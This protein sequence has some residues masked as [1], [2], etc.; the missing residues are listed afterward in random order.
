MERS[1]ELLLSARNISKSFGGIQALVN[2]RIDLYRGKICGMLGANGAGKSTFSNIIAGHISPSGGS[3]QYQG[4]PFTISSARDALNNGIALVAQETSLVPDL[5]VLENIFLPNLNQKG[6]LSFRL[7]RMRAN[8]ILS[9]LGGTHDL[10]LEREVKYLSAAQRQLI[11]IAKALALDANIIIFDE[12]TSSLSPREVENLFHVM[13]QIK[14]NDSALIFVS[15]RLEEVFSITDNVTILREGQCVAENLLTKELTQS[16]VIRYMVGKEI[17]NIYQMKRR[18][19]QSEHTI[20][21]ID[22]LKSQPWVQNVSFSLKKGEILGL[23]GLVGAGRSEAMEALMGI[24]P[25][26]AGKIQLNGKIANIKS[27]RS[28]IAAGL[29]FIAED[30]KTHNVFSDFNV[31]DNLMIA[32]MGQYKGIGRGYKKKVDKANKLLKEL[33]ISTARL[34]SNLTEF[35]GGMQQKIIIA[36]WLMIEPEILILDEPTKGVDIG[37]RVAIYKILCN[38]ADAGISCIVISSDFE[39][40]LGICERIVVLSDGLTIA[41]LPSFLLNEEKL[42]LLAAPRSSAKLNIKILKYLSNKYNCEAFW[43]LI[44]KDQI[45]CLALESSQGKPTTTGLEVGKATYAHQTAIPDALKHKKTDFFLERTNH[46]AT[47]LHQ[48]GNSRG[49]DFGW[50]GI[51]MQNSQ[52]KPS[53]NEIDSCISKMTSA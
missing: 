16:D 40:L 2:A 17:K 20:L 5:T 29:G 10:P 28:A 11:E 3:I 13:E 23:G 6:R 22:G 21:Q 12:P 9:T 8:E 4:K 24:R 1:S 49:L 37:T 52:E 35:S 38:A 7:L 44:D 47:F 32:H 48:I 41:D 42:A 18:N 33:N 30:R 53:T 36:R 26:Q 45:I 39:E 51:T 50:I 15:H 25:K 46:C 19:I 34:D 31:R 14:R 43:I 27:P